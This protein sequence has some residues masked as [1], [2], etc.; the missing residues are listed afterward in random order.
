VQ[1][2]A[3]HLALH[4]LAADAGHVGG[5]CLQLPPGEGGLRHN[6]I[7]LLHFADQAQA[8]RRHATTTTGEARQK[9]TLTAGVV[10]SGG[11]GRVAFRH[12]NSW[13]R[14]RPHRPIPELRTPPASVVLEYRLA[15]THSPP[16]STRAHTPPTFSSVWSSLST[17]AMRRMA[18]SRQTCGGAKRHKGCAGARAAESG[19]GG[20]G[21]AGSRNVVA[22]AA[23][24]HKHARTACV[25]VTAKGTTFRC[26]T[27]S[28]RSSSSAM[29][30]STW[31]PARFF[32]C[33]GAPR[34]SHGRT[35]ASEEES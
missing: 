7:L 18:S 5:G 14:T 21:Q 29:S 27:S 24:T 35:A 17:A 9:R 30:S 19:H 11:A 12:C 28:L 6:F 26:S 20:W 1:H 23:V 13:P 4:Q 34:R 10:A 16:K 25:C 3:A 33:G 32:A 15:A 8:G 22:S 2:S 31:S